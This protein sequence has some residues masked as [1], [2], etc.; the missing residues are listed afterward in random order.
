MARRAVCGSDAALPRP[1]LLTLRDSGIRRKR[2][3]RCR[4]GDC[5]RLGL[6]D[7]SEWV[8]GRRQKPWSS[9]PMDGSLRHLALAALV[10][11]AVPLAAQQ[12]VPMRGNTPVAPQGI[13]VPPLPDAPVRYETAE[14][15]NIRV[16]VYAR[17]FPNVVEPGVCVGRHDPRRRARGP[18]PRRA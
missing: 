18:D 7:R 8:K 16:V 4:P 3:G 1:R 6:R 11:L 13:K 2:G 5:R 15:Q 12:D 10:V 9:R 14:G 17:G